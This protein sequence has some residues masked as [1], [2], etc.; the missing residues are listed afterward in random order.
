MSKITIQSVESLNYNVRRFKTNK[1]EGYEFTPGQ[2]TLVS[3]DKDGL[4]EEKRPF[5]FTSLPEDDHLEFTIKIYPS[6]EGVTDELDELNPDDRLIIEDAWGAIEFKGKGTFI[7]GG[8]GVTPMLAILRD[9][10]RKESDFIEQIIFS[11]QEKKDLFLEEELRSLSGGNLLLTFTHENVEGA[12][13]GRVDQS[14]LRKHVQKTNQYF[15]VCGP[16][17]MVENLEEILKELGVDAEKIVTEE[18]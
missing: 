7:A 17:D 4:R 8:A 3:I 18:S 11:N 12:E 2:A 1:P 5:T 14:F 9:Q 16:P 13:Q 6:H 10:A 15:Y